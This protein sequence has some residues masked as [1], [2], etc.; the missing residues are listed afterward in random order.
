MEEVS[1]VQSVVGTQTSI[2]QSLLSLTRET[3]QGERSGALDEPA[4]ATQVSSSRMAHPSNLSSRPRDMEISYTGNYQSESARR[5]IPG[6]PDHVS[7]SVVAMR[8]QTRSHAYDR[9]APSYAHDYSE[10]PA[11]GYFIADDSS[12]D[13]KLASTDAG[14]YRVLLL[15]ECLQFLAGRKSDF[16]GFRDVAI[17]LKQAVRPPS[18]LFTQLKLHPFY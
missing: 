6:P 5:M 4:R 11:Y 9:G 1:V 13:F 7:A 17:F 16:S 3:G 2:F 18:M 8:G 14:G 15:N 12:S 10:V